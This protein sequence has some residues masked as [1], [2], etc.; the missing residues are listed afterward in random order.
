MLVCNRLCRLAKV[1]C[2]FNSF[3]IKSSFLDYAGLR[4]K[5]LL[6]LYNMKIKALGHGLEP[7]IAHA[8]VLLFPYCMCGSALTS[9]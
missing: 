8:L 2:V 3:F 9:I 6:H 5:A 1:L 7:N 4:V